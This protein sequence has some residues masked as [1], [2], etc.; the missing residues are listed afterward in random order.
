MAK[1]EWLFIDTQTVLWNNEEEFLYCFRQIKTIIQAHGKTV[2]E[3]DWQKAIHY[4]ISSFTNS[5]FEAIIWHLT[6]P[7]LQEFDTYFA[8]FEKHM[9]TLNADKIRA[10]YK[11]HQGALRVVHALS[12]NYEMLMCDTDII[13]GRKFLEDAGLDSIFSLNKQPYTG[14][15]YVKPDARFLST[16]I[17]KAGVDPEKSL[18]V[19]HRIDMDILP[20][21]ALGMKT[22][23]I[24]KGFYK[25]QEPRTPSEMPHLELDIIAKLPD[26]IKSIEM[27]GL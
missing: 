25:L 12:R 10:F 9:K 16:L 26:A 13:R 14:L 17:D 22:I 15:P 11:L 4:A 20:A 18:L 27:M 24:K 8:L 3:L 2:S 7:D 1:I 23:R 19:A 6:K 21:L 5:P